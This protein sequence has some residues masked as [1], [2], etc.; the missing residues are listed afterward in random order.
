[1]GQVA[2][3][4]SELPRDRRILVL[5]HHGSRSRQVAR[6]LRAQGFAAVSNIA[7]GIAEWARQIDP[8]MRQY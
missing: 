7:G 2:G 8:T 1:M 6:Q 3:R 4:M 5:C